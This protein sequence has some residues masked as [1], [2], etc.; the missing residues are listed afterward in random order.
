MNIEE[1]VAKIE[2]EQK[3]Y[4]DI[5][6]LAEALTPISDIALLLDLNLIELRAKIKDPHTRESLAYRK[7]KARG[8]LQVRQAAVKKAGDGDQTAA[9]TAQRFYNLMMDDENL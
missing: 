8:M 4:G 6:D 5:T 3:L 7:G 9:A 2:S 1:E